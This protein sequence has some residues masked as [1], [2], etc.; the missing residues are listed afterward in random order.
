VIRQVFRDSD[1]P[2]STH[3]VLSAAQKLKPQ[4]GIATVYR[5]LKLLI[6]SGWL[7]VVRL[8][9]EPPRYELADKP[10]HHHFHCRACGR[11]VEVP[12]SD[13]LLASLVPAGFHLEHHD[14]VLH[15]TCDRC[16]SPKPAIAQ[17]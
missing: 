5:S 15:G 1:R 14:L 2:L 9:G 17:D 12:G 7:S 3:E 13:S 11:V 16:D 8:P 10:H 4:I 6:D